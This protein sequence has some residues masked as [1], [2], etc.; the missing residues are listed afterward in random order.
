MVL[1]QCVACNIL[2]S[3]DVCDE[4]HLNRSNNF[5]F[6]VVLRSVSLPSFFIIFLPK[7]GRMCRL[8]KVQS[9]VNM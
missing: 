6:R 4:I 2:V 3:A 7:S 9:F 1:Q 5:H 8:G